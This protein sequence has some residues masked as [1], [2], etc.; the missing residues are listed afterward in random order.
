MIQAL[1]Q[2]GLALA[3]FGLPR[4]RDR[5]P[6]RPL[7]VDRRPR[8]HHAV[9]HRVRARRLPARQRLGQRQ[10]HASER[11]R[12]AHQHRG[13]GRRRHRRRS[14]HLDRRH[15]RQRHRR[16]RR[17]GR[18]P[19]RHRGRQCQPG[20]LRA[21]RAGRHR[22]SDLADRGDGGPVVARRGRCRSRWAAPS[23]AS[24]CSARPPTRT[25][26]SFYSWAIPINVSTT[27]QSGLPVPITLAFGGQITLLSTVTTPV[28]E[29]A[30]FGL[31][32]LGL[33][34]VGAALRRRG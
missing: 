8:A 27:I 24:A 5:G 2:P 11:L 21:Q 22:D 30:S 7:A 13:A 15:R 9:D 25:V 12:C 4:R 1:R 23:R 18:R 28:P 3:A 6:S 29:P 34:A 17:P 33:V 10:R 32:A 16:D 26:S 20:G 31:M 14:D 19:G